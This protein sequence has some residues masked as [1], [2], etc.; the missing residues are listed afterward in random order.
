MSL[1]EISI[2]IGLDK[3]NPS[4][5]SS[6][7]RRYG[8]KVRSEDRCQE[9]WDIEHVKVW[10]VLYWEQGKSLSEISKLSGVPATQ[11]S[12][13]FKRYGV[14]T[15]SVSE[16]TRSYTLDDYV[17]NTIDSHEKAYWLGFIMADGCVSVRVD[18]E[19]EIYE[20]RLVI[21]LQ[22]SDIRTLEVLSKFLKTDRP[23]TYKKSITRVFSNG[24]KY[25][26][27]PQFFCCDF[28]IHPYNSYHTES[29]VW[30]FFL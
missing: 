16:G 30:G 6:V 14:K 25:T 24:K 20:Y 22:K 3:K 1:G 12:K 18:K 17:F 13:A 11:I 21:A 10:K 19:K 27:K 5:I 28:T 15:R 9:K 8:F 29:H 2:S 23:L 26:S 7:M 4:L